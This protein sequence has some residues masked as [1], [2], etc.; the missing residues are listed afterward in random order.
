MISLYGQ[1]TYFVVSEFSPAY[2]MCKSAQKW[3]MH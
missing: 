1:N 3:I 2:K